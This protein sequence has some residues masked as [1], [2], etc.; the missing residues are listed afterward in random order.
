MTRY[1]VVT[2]LL[3]ALLAVAFFF[4]LCYKLPPDIYVGQGIMDVVQDHMSVSALVIG[5]LRLPRL[6]LALLIGAALGLA[7]ANL[8]ASM[9]NPLADPGILGITGW[10]SLGGVL[11][12]YT[13]F[14]SG[15]PVLI[16][17]AAFTGA[18]FAAVIL[19]TLSRGG[20]FVMT[21]AGIALSTLSAALLSLI[22]NLVPSPY[23]RFEIAHWL[24]GSLNQADSQALF[25]AFPGLVA[26]C[27]L[28]SVT[29]RS[30]DGLSLGENIAR[31]MG[32]RPHYT[33]C[34]IIG[35][36]VLSLGSAVAVAGNIAFIGLV[37]PH[38]ARFLVGYK[39]SDTLVPSALLGAV[40][41]IGADGLVHVSVLANH[42]PLG[43]VTTLIGTPFFLFQ[44][45]KLYRVQNV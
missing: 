44:I 37:V 11:V 45:W 32:I 13:D 2:M 36:C 40:L 16:A 3:G 5:Q 8:Q 24:L 30:L 7:G 42:L 4:S 6:V 14:L 1:Q 17:C 39:P 38:I 21:L 12:F 19:F 15:G 29:G 9:R 34:L 43:V 23:A 26:G 35:G 27:L 10:A 31:S 18:L 22:L 41:L 25:M 20:I 33:Q 28:L